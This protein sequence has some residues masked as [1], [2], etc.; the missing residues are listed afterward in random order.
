MSME[1]VKRLFGR[2]RILAP[3]RILAPERSTPLT[4]YRWRSFPE[5]G[6][7]HSR[8]IDAMSEQAGRTGSLGDRPVVVPDGRRGAHDAGCLRLL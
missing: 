1:L 8:W 2:S 7:A 5:G 3:Y 6:L 4:A